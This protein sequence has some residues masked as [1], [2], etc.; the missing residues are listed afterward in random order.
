[1][2]AF[3]LV[4]VPLVPWSRLDVG[5]LEMNV[6]V[7]SWMCKFRLVG[8]CRLRGLGSVPFPGT[9]PAIELLRPFLEEGL[10]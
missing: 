3:S 8:V 5:A 10:K 4:A 2:V 1:M 7:V 9:L 6:L